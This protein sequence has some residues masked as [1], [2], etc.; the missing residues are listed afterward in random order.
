MKSKIWLSP[1]HLTGLEVDFVSGAITSNW[2]APAGPSVDA[3]EHALGKYLSINGVA[4]LS[5]GTAALHLALDVLGVGKG[6]LVLCQTLTF[7]ASANPIRYLGATPIFID[8]EPS[9]WN[10]CPNAL[11]DAVKSCLKRGKKPKALIGVHLYGMPFMVDEILTIC[12]KYAIP[13]I[14]DAA[15]A[16]GSR[17]K[18]KKLGSFGS[19]ST[20]SFNGNKIITTSGGGALCSND[21]TLIQKS[22]FLASQARDNAPHYEH[23]KIG[24]NYGLSNILAAIGLAQLAVIEDRV[25]SRRQ[26]FEFYR[27]SL[28][29]S[30]GISFVPE[31]A[32]CISNRWLT[33]ILVDPNA[34]AG[35]TREH[36]RLDLLTENIESRPVWKPLHLQPAF[37]TAKYFGG[38]VAANLF[39]DGLC[40]PSG[41]NLTDADRMRITLCIKKS[42]HRSGERI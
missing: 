9:T 42:L 33:A 41:S 2:I 11:E 4:A 29:G 7:I 20:L 32:H 26:N 35:I 6:D 40:L 24:Y 14:E 30:P 10:I 15:E 13:L 28:M 18:N 34:S 36:I 17:Y 19:I 8:S 38:N 25:I 12:Q 23:S 27:N 21:T 3:F 31:P 5:S 39:R 37:K 1:P 16:L 22:R